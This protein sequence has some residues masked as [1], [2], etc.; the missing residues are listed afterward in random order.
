MYYIYKLYCICTHKTK[1]RVVI[2]NEIL[3]QY[4]T[5]IIFYMDLYNI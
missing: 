2:G 4:I 1:I 5:N 3:Y